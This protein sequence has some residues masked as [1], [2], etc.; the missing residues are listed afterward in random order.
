VFKVKVE[1]DQAELRKL[2]R[3]LNKLPEKTAK[4]VFRGALRKAARIVQK[5]AKANAPRGET[6]NL[7]EGILINLKERS[8]GVR[9]IELDAW[10]GLRLKPRER[11]AWYGRLIETGWMLKLR[12]GSRKHIRAHPFLRPAFHK[13]VR[14]MV[15]VF[16][17]A[18]RRSLD[19]LAK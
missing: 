17:K 10:I 19:R 4:R 16:Q 9:G 12:D 15:Q 8:L 11:S 13:N 18:L 1:V 7:A 6:G 3:R 5:E 14:K 2:E